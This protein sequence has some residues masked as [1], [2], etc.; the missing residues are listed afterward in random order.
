M[1]VNSNIYYTRFMRILFFAFTVLILYYHSAQAADTLRL[2]LDECIELAI[3][4]SPD[5]DRTRVDSLSAENKWLSVKAKRFPQLKFSGELPSRREAID[6]SIAYDPDS[7]KE[8]YQRVSS[9]ETRWQSQILLEQELPWGATF[10]VS[11]RL[12]QSDWFN[13]R[14]GSGR[15]TTEYSWRRRASLRQ[16]VLNG[17]PIGRSRKIGF[18]D[19]QSAMIDREIGMKELTYSVTEA[20]FGFVSASGALEIAR[21]DLQIGRSSETLAKRKLK[22]GLIPE[23]ELLQIQLDL[24]RR[25]ASY[26]QNDLYVQSA[27]DRL[28]VILG[29]PLDQAFMTNW[30][31]TAIDN[32]ELVADPDGTRLELLRAELRL[33]SIE[34]V[35]KASRLSERI[36]A[37][38]Q[39]YYEVDS[40]QPEF[41]SLGD[42]GDQNYGLVLFIDVPLYGFGYT[43]SIIEQKKTDLRRAKLDLEK[44]RIELQ[45]EKRRL[46]RTM[47]QSYERI[48]IAIETLELSEKTY[49]ITS[50][51]F[52]GGLIDSRE[53]IDAQF[54]LTRARREALNARIDYELAVANFL[55]ITSEKNNHFVQ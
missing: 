14:I 34:I 41:E 18:Y 4:Q 23:V 24:S 3:R 29:L 51:R 36:D 42:K 48:G 8:E 11:T 10:D 1:I 30:T 35:N 27:K 43:K 47:S 54:N 44:R 32:T 55:R 15:D 20:F 25:K 21:K 39:V 12:Y 52:D 45:T 2:S 31:P 33:A 9:G 17:N 49:S 16:P 53:L 50:E 26:T 19:Y 37:S 7:D 13:D 40:R 38:L 5:A 46:Q 6:Y 28:C 22:A